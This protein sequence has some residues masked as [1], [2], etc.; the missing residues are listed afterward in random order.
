MAPHLPIPVPTW[1]TADSPSRVVAR[2]AVTTVTVVASNDDC[3]N[4]T[5][6]S[7]GAIAGIVIG[8]IAGFLLLLWI[9]RS[10]FNLGAPPKEREKAWLK[11]ARAQPKLPRILYLLGT[12][13]CDQ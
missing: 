1:T 13:G 6:L 8:S 2:Q 9:I 11:T 4:C 3:V 12:G 10:C 7:G 5:Q